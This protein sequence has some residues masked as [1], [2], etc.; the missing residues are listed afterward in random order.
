[1]FISS[2]SSGMIWC[3]DQSTSAVSI[4]SLNVIPTTQTLKKK[5]ELKLKK[6][7]KCVNEFSKDE[8]EKLTQSWNGH[9]DTRVF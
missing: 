1:M 8:K 2:F 3:G 5:K 9:M 7:K 4:P 6:L